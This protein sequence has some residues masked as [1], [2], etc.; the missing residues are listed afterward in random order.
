VKIELVSHTINAREILIYT[1]SGRL[2]HDVTF[3]E[4]LNWPEEKKQ[5]HLEY[6]FDTIQTSL[7]FVD[8][9]FKIS[10]VS[11]AFTHQLVRTRTASFQQES[12]RTVNVSDHGWVTPDGL[13]D[14]QNAEYTDAMAEA[15]SN[16]E[17]LINCGLQRQDARGVIPTNIKTS[18]F[19][20]VNLRTL[21]DMANTRL[22][23]RTQGEYQKAFQKMKAQILIFHPWAEPLLQVACAKTG[24]CI[25]P[26]YMEC[27]IADLTYNN[28]INNTKAHELKLKG[29]KRAH[30]NIDHV[31]APVAK[32]GVTM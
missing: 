24:I 5:E 20:K 3:A 6:M 13:T 9:T 30:K 7:E 32:E 29:I 21:S 22:C 23:Y 2:A 10:G 19:M 11:R 15:V 8:Y 18:I 26:R 17:H 12:Q 28:H 14:E 25:F 4:I 31:A 27:P 16:Y 1:K